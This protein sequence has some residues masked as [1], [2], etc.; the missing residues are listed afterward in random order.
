MLII[1]NLG[2]QAISFGMAF[3]ILTWILGAGYAVVLAGAFTAVLIF[4]TWSVYP[5]YFFGKRVRK[6]MTKWKLAKWHK[7]NATGDVH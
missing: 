2:K 6:A 7:Q 4:I 1:I 5:F 3:K